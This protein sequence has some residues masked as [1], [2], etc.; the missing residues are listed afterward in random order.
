MDDPSDPF[1]PLPFRHIRQPLDR[2]TD[3]ERGEIQS[4]ALGGFERINAALRGQLPM[5]PLL[6]DGIATLRDAIRKFPLDEDARVTREIAAADLGLITADAAPTV[7]GELFTEPAFLSVS[8]NEQPPRAASR[9]NPIDLDLRVPAGTPAL[10]L[11]NLAEFPLER[12]LLVIDARRLFFVD[13]QYKV[14]AGRWR[15]F[16]EVI[17]DQLGGA[18]T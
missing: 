12:E 18:G 2:L 15:L 4:Y 10:S 14:A 3:H 16:G 5:T 7:V 17:P 6:E 9:L 13:C 1:A 8:M 11:G